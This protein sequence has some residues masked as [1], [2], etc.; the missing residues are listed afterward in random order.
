MPCFSAVF[1]DIQIGVSDSGPHISTNNKPNWDIY[2]SKSKFGCWQPETDQI[3]KIED[4]AIVSW[5][6]K[7]FVFL[8]LTQYIPFTALVSNK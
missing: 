1:E 4:V 3:L 5:L 7:H 6:A 2:I 8:L